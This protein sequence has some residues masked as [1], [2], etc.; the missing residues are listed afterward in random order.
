MYITPVAHD[1][2]PLALQKS[3]EDRH[4]VR[5]YRRMV[6]ALKYT[7]RYSTD[8]VVVAVVTKVLADAG[9]I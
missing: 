8:T 2:I 1:L 5:Y 9:E 6:E 7:M 4:K 3:K